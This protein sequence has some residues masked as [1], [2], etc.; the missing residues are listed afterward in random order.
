MSGGIPAEMLHEWLGGNALLPAL[1]LKD[2]SVVGMMLMKMTQAAGRMLDSYRH[3][4]SVRKK[5]SGE[6]QKS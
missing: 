1:P 3:C 6:L 4:K 5:V 2:I